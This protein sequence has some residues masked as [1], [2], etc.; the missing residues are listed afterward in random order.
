MNAMQNTESLMIGHGRPQNDKKKISQAFPECDACRRL[1][2]AR[3][4]T[5]A[6]VPRTS[7]AWYACHRLA[8]ATSST[9]EEVHPSAKSI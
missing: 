2:D 4:R 5:G 6:K 9:I 1:A 8:D 3:V 7:S